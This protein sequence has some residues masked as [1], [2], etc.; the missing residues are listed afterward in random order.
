MRTLYRLTAL[1]T[2]ASLATAASAQG[3]VATESGIDWHGFYMGLNAGGAWNTTCTT[4][5]ANGPLVNTAA[6]NNR[7]CPN[8]GVFVGGGQI[9]YN[10]Q[11]D[12]WVWGFELDYDYWSST[13]HNRTLVYSGPGLPNGTYAFSG[14]ISPDGFLILGPRLGYAIDNW[15]PYLRAGAVFTSGSHD[16]I[17]TYTPTGVAAPTATFDAGKNSASH[18][19]GISVGFEYALPQQWSAKAEYTYV[20]LSKGSN[21]GVSCTPAGAACNE[22]ANFTLDSIHN[23]FTASVLRVGVNYRF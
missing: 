22:F 10:F 2:F 1:L 20:S 19:F 15:L 16:L 5:T 14:K 18:G 4:W 12:Q 13:N 11:S 9:G 8:N 3:V 17:A 6:F 7:D 21:S 23:N